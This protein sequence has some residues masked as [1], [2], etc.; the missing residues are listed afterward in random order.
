MD[1]SSGNEEDRA[2]SMR[3]LA[4]SQT[5]ASGG[6]SNLLVQLTIYS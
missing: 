4:G 5:E 1:D 3:S 2:L 6:I